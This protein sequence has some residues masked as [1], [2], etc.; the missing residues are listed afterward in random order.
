VMPTFSAAS[1]MVRYSISRSREVETPRAA[2]LT[3]AV[4]GFRSFAGTCANGEVAPIPA[5]RRISINPEV[6][7][8]R[9]LAMP[10]ARGGLAPLDGLFAFA[11]VQAFASYL[12]SI[13]NAAHTHR[14]RGNRWADDP[15]AIAEMPQSVGAR[16]ISSQH[17]V[18]AQLLV[19]LGERRQ[20][21]DLPRLLRQHMGRSIGCRGYGRT[22]C[23]SIAQ[24]KA[25]PIPERRPALFRLDHVHRRG[26]AASGRRKRPRQGRGRHGLPVSVEPPSG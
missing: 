2:C 6:R 26:V 12:C 22:S 9:A 3:S 24:E 23:R 10:A 21:H 19:R 11:Q 7:P 16:N 5:I 18:D 4:G 1:N 15:A 17:R 14:M 8:C 20:A 13:V 25:D